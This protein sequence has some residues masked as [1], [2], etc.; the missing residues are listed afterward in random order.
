MTPQEKIN[1]LLVDD[2]PQNLLSLEALLDSPD[3]HLVKAHSGKEALKHLL[4]ED[5]ALIL[6]D[7]RMPDLDGLETAKLIKQREQSKYIPIIFLTALQ[8]DEQQL[9]EGYSAGAVDY[10]LKPFKRESL[11]RYITRHRRSSIQ[12]S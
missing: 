4:K 5:F 12:P 1:I 11:I 2:H 7:V 3:Y 10:V 9:F 6:L 8:Q